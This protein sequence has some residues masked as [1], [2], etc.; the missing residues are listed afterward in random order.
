M[1]NIDKILFFARNSIS[2]YCINDCKAHC[3]KTGKLLIF[4]IEELNSITKNDNLKYT[5]NKNITQNDAGNFYFD[6]EKNGGCPNLNLNSFKCA[7]HKDKNKPK[8]CTDF[9][10]FKADGYIV[11]ASICP[12]VQN[13]MFE[14]HFKEI[15][16][17]G[18]KII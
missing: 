10:L 1:D 7:I 4:S 11:S 6:L 18:Y 14:K 12:A 15:E 8:V 16:K 3:C 13:K 9:P 2:S 5:L 17:L